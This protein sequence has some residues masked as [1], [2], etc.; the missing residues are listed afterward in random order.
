[1]SKYV[2]PAAPVGEESDQAPDVKEAPDVLLVAD[3]SSLSTPATDALVKYLRAGNPAVILVDPLPFRWTFQ[4]PG[5]RGIGILNAPRQNRVS[6]RSPYAQVLS[7]SEMPKDSG[8]TADK[9]L[10]VLGVEWDNGQAAW[11]LVNPHHSFNGAYPAYLGPTWPEYY[12]PYERAFVWVKND[13]DSTAFNK[14]EVI[15]SGLKQLLFFYPGTIK[16]SAEVNC[17]FSPLVT[18][19]TDSGVTNWQELTT[20]PTRRIARLDPRTR[21]RV[22]DEQPMRSQITQEPQLVLQPNPASYLDDNE[23]V[24]SAKVTNGDVNAVVI[25]DLD[26]VSEIFYSQQGSA[27]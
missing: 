19:G 14:D 23:Y 27:R 5:P 16:K 25:A 10:T 21:G 6:P 11:S 26:F 4:N 3:P 13:G 17:D 24:L 12:G 7:S 18:L 1:M 9:I 8:G 22:I 2:E 15:S 20:S